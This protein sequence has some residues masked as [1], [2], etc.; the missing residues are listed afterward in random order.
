LQKR[1]I[2]SIS[3]DLWNTN[4]RLKFG[5]I[6]YSFNFLNVLGRQWKECPIL[7]SDFLPY[8]MFSNC[9]LRNISM[10]TYIID[11]KSLIM[12]ALEHITQIVL[13]T[14]RAFEHHSGL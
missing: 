3:C 10:G 2:L 14:P 7:A 13:P 11:V 8:V 12:S 4:W 5:F 6:Y 1:A 9:V